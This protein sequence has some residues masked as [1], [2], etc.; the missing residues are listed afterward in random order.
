MAVTICEACAKA[1]DDCGIACEKHPDDKHMQECGK[2]CRACAKAC[3][4]MIKHA[5]QEQGK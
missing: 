5:G 4:D 2:A 3:R 1:C